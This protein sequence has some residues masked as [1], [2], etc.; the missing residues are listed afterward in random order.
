MVIWRLCA[1]KLI[2]IIL[3][4][5]GFFPSKKHDSIVFRQFCMKFLEEITKNKKIM[6][7]NV[8]FYF[9]HFSQKA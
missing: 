9:L 3:A 4:E 2:N 7:I 5:F 6:K 8:L 1:K